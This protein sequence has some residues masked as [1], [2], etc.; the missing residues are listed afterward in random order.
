MSNEVESGFSV[1][2]SS[3]TVIELFSCTTE[4]GEGSKRGNQ[5]FC[6]HFIII[7]K[8]LISSAPLK[9]AELAIKLSF[10]TKSV[11][12]LK[13]IHDLIIINNQA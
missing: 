8:R 4:I 11:R 7:I 13:F 5:K 1:D 6:L 3:H 12:L 10:H 9:S 2:F